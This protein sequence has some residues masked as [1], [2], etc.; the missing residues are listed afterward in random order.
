YLQKFVVAF[1]K[2]HLLTGPSRTRQHGGGHSSGTKDNVPP[3]KLQQV[4]LQIIEPSM[5]DSAEDRLT[6][7]VTEETN[8][9]VNALIHWAPT[10]GQHHYEWFVL[11]LE[12]KEQGFP[13]CSGRVVC[14]N[15]KNLS[16]G[17]PDSNPKV[18]FRSPDRPVTAI[19]AYKMSSLLI[20]VGTE[21]HLHHL[22]FA[23]RK[24]KTLSK[25]PLPSHAKT[26]TCQGSLIFVA[27]AH[28]SLF[29]LV[30]R[31][32]KLSQHK[33]DNKARSTMDVVPFDGT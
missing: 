17:V 9:S 21:L 32:N 6:I 2:T 29:V 18:A 7:L 22:D 33:S 30:E 19:C 5:K 13:Q 20:A 15:A 12:Q 10:D 31:D 8:E 3:R 26:I 1:E 4:G 24:W 16:K 14:V 23:T 27:T 11:A 25:H 28:H